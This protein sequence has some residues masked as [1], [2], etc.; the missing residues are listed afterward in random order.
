ML[1]GTNVLPLSAESC[2]LSPFI[3]PRLTGGR[4]TLQTAWFR[5]STMS[6]I[7]QKKVIVPLVARQKL[8]G[9]VLIRY[10]LGAAVMYDNSLHL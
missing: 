10:K 8:V 1:R 9:P 5:N 4:R 2:Y 7:F 3:L 6:S